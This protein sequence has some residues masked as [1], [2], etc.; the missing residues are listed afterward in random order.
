MAKH[1]QLTVE[2]AIEKAETAT[3]QGNLKLAMQLYEAVL[4]L[5]PDHPVASKNAAG[6]RQASA[7][8]TGGASPDPPPDVSRALLQLYRSGQ[9]K[10]AEHA[11][12]DALNTYG[13]SPFLFNLLGAILQGGGRYADAVAAF[14]GAVELKPDHAQAL[15]NRGMARAA[16][17]QTEQALGD[18]NRAVQ[19]KPGYAHA[20]INRGNIFRAMGKTDAA[21]ADYDT[22]IR[23]KPDIPET[24]SN[25]GNA[26]RDQGRLNAAM[27]DYEEAIR[28]N[29]G[30]AEALS[31]RGSLFK[32][33]GRPE[34][35][36]ADFDRAIRLKPDFAEAYNGRGSTLNE[37]GR[38]A[39]AV[40]DYDRALKINP[41]Y[42]EACHNRG[43]VLRDLGKLE[44]AVE[45]YDQAIRIRPDYGDAHNNRGSALAEL[46][47]V[48]AAVASYETALRIQP[49]TAWAHRN[50]SIIKTY[51]P[52]DPQI[53]VMEGLLE[54]PAVDMTDRVHLLFALAKAYG[55]T[56]AYDR[57]FACLEK[58]NRLRKKELAYG[59]EHDRDIMTRVMDLFDIPD[60]SAVASGADDPGL[61]PVF[62][63]G[64]PRSGTSLVEQIL[65]S[66][67]RV[68]GAGELNTVSRLVAPVL[69]RSR[70]T[71]SKQTRSRQKQ[72]GPDHIESL[73]S[74]IEVLRR[75]YLADLAALDIP[76]PKTVI[77]DKMP[78]NFRYIGFILSAFPDARLIH[79]KRD[80]MAV[81]W[82]VF[83]HYFS[84]GGNRYAYDMAD[85]AAFY[86][87]YTDMMAFWHRCF[88]GKILEFSYERLTED[89]EGQ[90][91]RLLAYC[92]LSWEPNCLDFHRTKRAVKT[93]ST[94]QVR[95]KI[96]QGSSDA[97]RTYEKHLQPLAQALEAQGISL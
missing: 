31:N 78:L 15:C 89:Q 23:L 96:Y 3:R 85:L 48:E 18:Y 62:I 16:L 20:Y 81:C 91:R 52:S 26:F 33:L 37:M 66:H 68:F 22:A 63:V 60:L 46:G 29:P 24:F 72:A 44:A 30:F 4:Q 97:W 49:D 53:G 67:S 79:L 7:A 80:P 64:M 54:N 38:P 73:A 92:G 32:T 90:T 8:P 87:L 75:G 11:C 5:V 70:Q 6:L 83:R 86:K 14:D 10:K 36:L 25:R 1:Q 82:S 41:A 93:A 59:I 39:E 17:G 58:G 47:Q 28:L 69:A 84:E 42:A 94:A 88:P 27:A 12:N 35:A 65:A 43:N 74:D 56:G 45:S 71:R 51:T 55:D 2:Q 13:R 57:S 19:C 95:R 34:R 50:L 61:T 77:T 21:V 9:L 40:S 76:E